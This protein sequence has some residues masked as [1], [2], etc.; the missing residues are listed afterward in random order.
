MAKRAGL[1]ASTIGRIW[2]RF[3]L[4]PHLVDGFEL[5]GLVA[6]WLADLARDV[7]ISPVQF[8]KTIGDA[9]M[10]VCSDPLKLLVT[11]LDLVDAAVAD[12][13]PRLRIGL[14][15]VTP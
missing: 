12:D 10:L 3:G 7:V 14:A 15:S 8:V 2:R 5:L 6:I 4:K 11:V 13:F 1:S 9:V